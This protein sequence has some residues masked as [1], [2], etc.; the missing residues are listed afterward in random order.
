MMVWKMIFLFNWVIV[1]FHVNLPGCKNT[2][3]NKMGG[4]LVRRCLVDE[5]NGEDM[6]LKVFG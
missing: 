2:R 1:R 6:L 3:M 4:D 5:K